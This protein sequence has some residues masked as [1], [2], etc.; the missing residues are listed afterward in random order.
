[1]AETP[2]ATCNACGINLAT[3]QVA[4]DHRAAA[5]DLSAKSEGVYHPIQVINPPRELVISNHVKGL[6]FQ[7]IQNFLGDLEKLVDAN[8]V[9]SAEI[10]EALRSTRSLPIGAM[11]T[12]MVQR[13]TPPTPAV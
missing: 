8:D 7:A 4:V 3:E 11:W 2:Y 10:A 12:E 13:R 9:T 5:G 1:M 6:Q